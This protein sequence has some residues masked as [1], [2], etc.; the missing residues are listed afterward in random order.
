[1]SLTFRWLGVAGVELIADGQVLA[2]DPF[3]TRPTLK[4]LLH[5]LNPHPALAVERLPECQHVLVTHSHYDHLL[6]VPDVLRHTGAIAYGSPN[7]CQLLSLLGIPASQLHERH[8]GESLSLGAFEVQVIAGRHSWIPLGAW[9]NA[10]LRPG[11]QPP[12]RALD[13]RM[14]VCLGYLIT[15]LGTRLLVCA[16]EPRPADVVFAVAQ[17][18]RQYYR[19]LLAGAQPRTFV[20]IHW[21]NFTRPLNLPLRRLRRPGR[22]TLEQLTGLA[23]HILPGMNVIIPEI[24][25]EYVL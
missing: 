20:A 14:D 16:A 10:P 4:E 7:T 18:P 6:D 11:L 12:L 21:D 24:F 8:V 25:R 19:R 17:E 13:Y 3:F 9:F 1:V 15:V 23:H 22:L 5:P 2:L